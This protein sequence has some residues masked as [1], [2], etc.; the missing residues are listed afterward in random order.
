M[1]DAGV[2]LADLS[3]M[4]WYVVLLHFWSDEGIWE[5]VRLEYRRL[6][7]LGSHFLILFHPKGAAT[8]RF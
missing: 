5:G 3:L 2:L 7:V 6:L 8:V 1:R 4:R